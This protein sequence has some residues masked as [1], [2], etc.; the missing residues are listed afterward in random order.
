MVEKL[1]QA[2]HLALR[3]SDEMIHRAGEPG[4]RLRNLVARGSVLCL[5]RMPMLC[6][7]VLLCSGEREVWMVK[8]LY[9][10][11]FLP[12]LWVQG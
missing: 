12:P 8:V 5:K 9:V 11:V 6:G 2:A 4:A 10:V 1:L 7:S 3:L